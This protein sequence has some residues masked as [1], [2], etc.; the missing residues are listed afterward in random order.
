[1]DDLS[2]G[3]VYTPYPIGVV[4]KGRPARRFAQFRRTYWD[5]NEIDGVFDWLGD[6][7][8]ADPADA[9][10]GSDSEATGEDDDCAGGG[11]ESEES[12]D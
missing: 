11:G 12:S 5:W 1:M 2:E 7:D 9:A 10:G 8:E 4:K 6:E 3:R